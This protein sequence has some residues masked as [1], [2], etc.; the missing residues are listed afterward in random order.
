MDKFKESLSEEDR[1]QLYGP[2]VEGKPEKVE[3]VKKTKKISKK[4]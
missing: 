4:K 3:K 1:I 2:E